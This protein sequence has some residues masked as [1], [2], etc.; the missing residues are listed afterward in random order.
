LLAKHLGDISYHA[1]LLTQLGRAQGLQRKFGEA[2]ATLDEAQNLITN[3][4][5]Q[6]RIRYLL[7]RGRVFNSSKQPEKARPLFLEA[8]ETAMAEKEDFYAVDA[9][10]MMG[11]IEPPEEQMEWNLRAIAVAEEST[12]QRAR[13]WL[14][15]LY[16]NMGWA[17][18]GQGQ[19]EKA[20]ECFEKALKYRE[21]Y[22][23]VTEVRVARWC[24]ARALRSLNRIE[25]AFTIQKALL[26]ESERLGEHDG[27]VYEEIAECLTV[28]GRSDEARPYFELAYRQLSQ[29]PWLVEDEPA[30]LERLKELGKSP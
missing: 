10:H 16:N 25:E 20:L 13:K 4:L 22:G 29:D 7:E 21:E 5:R 3:D 30:R 23:P 6:A 1:Q 24:I 26:D 12:E 18:H 11:I 8:W 9:A 2:H 28:L 19:Y 14:G 17:V 15:S 27:Y